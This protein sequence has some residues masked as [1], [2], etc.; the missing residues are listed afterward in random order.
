MVRQIL[1]TAACLSTLHCLKAQQSF[2][3][4][5]DSVR[6]RQM[7]LVIRNA[8][9]NVKGYLRNADN[10]KTE[11]QPLGHAI[12][13]A[14]GTGGFPQAGDSIYSNNHFKG[15]HIKIWRNGLLQCI[16]CPAAQLVD[17]SQGKINFRPALLL[18]ERI[19]IEAYR[20]ADFS[21]SPV[22]FID[23]PRFALSGFRKAYY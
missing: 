1:L 22:P 19:Y 6:A 8:S 9:K 14:V 2:G 13:F 17:T 10:G 5:R 7:E 21:Y 18:S 11:F 3:V 16:T 12:Q 4:I 23:L 15:S 20:F